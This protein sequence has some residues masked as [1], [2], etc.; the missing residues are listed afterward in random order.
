MD[1][2]FKVP[3]QTAFTGQP[4]IFWKEGDFIKVWAFGINWH[5]SLIESRE[6]AKDII[7]VLGDEWEPPQGPSRFHIE[8]DRDSGSVLITQGSATLVLQD[9]RAEELCK[10]L[11]EVA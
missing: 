7:A 4:A 9:S 5:I 11:K 8:Y 1:L 3:C 10:W 6:L 2:S